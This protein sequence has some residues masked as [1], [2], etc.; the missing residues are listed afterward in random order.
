MKTRQL[1]TALGSAKLS[2]F[3]GKSYVHNVF[4]CNTLTDTSQYQQ[5]PYIIP[6]YIDLYIQS[7]SGQK[8]YLCYNKIISDGQGVELLPDNFN[9]FLDSSQNELIINVSC[10]D[11]SNPRSKVSITVNYEP[12]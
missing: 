9:A 5:Y 7:K 1:N 4:L 11:Y 3:S 2:S 12:L 10:R 6:I 8:T